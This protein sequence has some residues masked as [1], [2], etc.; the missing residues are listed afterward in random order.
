MKNNL[1]Q[2]E[3][4]SSL[5][6]VYEYKGKYLFEDF[7]LQLEL[8][9]DIDR[10]RFF[11]DVDSTTATVMA[12]LLCEQIAG[13]K[14]NV[15]QTMKYLGYKTINYL[16]VSAQLNELKKK[17][18]L[19]PNKS[20][21]EVE[22]MDDYYFSK[23]IMNAILLNDKKLLET[24]VPDNIIKA[25]FS[26]MKFF[27]NAM[28]DADNEYLVE[29]VLDYVTHFRCFT[30]IDSVFKNELITNPEKAVLFFIMAYTTAGVDEFDLNYD[31]DKFCADPSFSYVFKNRVRSE[32]SILF[33]EEFL[34]FN[35]PFLADFSKVSLG[36]RLRDE[37]EIMDSE[38]KPF[39]PK[40]SQ[41]I[42]PDVIIEKK[43][44]FNEENQKQI[45]EVF[46]LTSDAYDAVMA[47]FEEH[48]LQT[49]LTL[50]FHGAAGTGKTEL[51]KQLAKQNNRVILIV[52]MSQLHNMFVGQSQ[53]NIKQLFT[54]YKNAMKYYER[55]PILL[56]NEADA[57]I[58]KRGVVEKSVDQMYNSV[59]NQLL[60]ELED[61]KGIFIATTNMLINI[62]TAFD[63]RMLYKLHFE[64]PNK[65]T[66][67]AIL[68]QSFIDDVDE[69]LLVK[70]STDY[71]LTGGQIDNI[72]K[73]C[74]TE[75][76]L[77]GTATSEP[78]KFISYIEQEINFRKNKSDKIGF[79]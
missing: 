32:K 69:G 59:L 28:A 55:T 44:F 2:N 60:Q 11:F 16:E 21:Y 22:S 39:K 51:V 7:E 50:L 23:E 42:L 61:F 12:V 67:L 72:K 70:A 30:V 48:G 74:L 25:M 35:E 57:I 17:G 27:K 68:K 76:L 29:I 26:I 1:Y 33:K 37:L 54:E 10:I 18:W 36:D 78:S 19:V 31:L 43:L 24:I 49:G 4:I 62:D 75:K 47:R 56:F 46:Q 34:V 65:E 79:A 45:D 73:R 64:K 15:N 40:L 6:A 41:V 52:D 53:R 58:S 38:V 13:N 14:F 8:K 9:E 5:C 20:Q 66:R 63:R 3:L 77:F 71:S